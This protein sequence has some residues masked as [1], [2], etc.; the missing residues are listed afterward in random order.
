[1]STLDSADLDRQQQLP[2]RPP[3]RY[4][5]RQG[6]GFLAKKDWSSTNTTRPAWFP[7]RSSATA[8]AWRWPRVHLDRQLNLAKSALAIRFAYGLYQME[9]DISLILFPNCP[10]FSH[11][12]KQERFSQG[13]KWQKGLKLRPRPASGPS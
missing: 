12:R 8:S 6:A 3:G 4:F 5:G 9:R 11:K 10:G 1:M 2:S 7:I 13:S